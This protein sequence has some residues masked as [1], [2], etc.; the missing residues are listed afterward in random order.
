MNHYVRVFTPAILLG[1]G[2]MFIS[3]IREQHTTR[4]RLPITN[5]SRDFTGL[6]GMDVEIDSTERKVAG[7]TDYML[8]EYRRDSSQVF[9]TYVGYYDKQV[10]GKTIHSPKNCLPGAGWDILE[11]KEVALPNAPDGRVNRV[12]L[13]NKGVKALVY[14]WYQGRGRIESNEYQVKWNLLRDAAMY[15]RTEEA[16]VRIVVPILH[17]KLVE[18]GYQG[19][20]SVEEADAL[21]REVAAGLVTEVTKVL[22]T[23]PDA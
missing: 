14:Y 23:A 2:V 12:L 7:M 17:P 16:L 9:T 8:R 15:G 3:G 10:Q 4:P 1:V 5:I 18:R 22:P 11:S 6:R 13:A 20:K 21:A 19:A